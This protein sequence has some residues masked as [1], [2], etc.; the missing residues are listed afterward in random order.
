MLTR[1]I[2]DD[3]LDRALREDAPWGDLT[4]DA[5]VDPRSRT[6]AVLRAREAGVLAGM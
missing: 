1:T 3:A 6:T 4:V 2:I 5:L